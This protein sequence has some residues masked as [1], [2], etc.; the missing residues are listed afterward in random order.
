MAVVEGSCWWK[1]GEQQCTCTV[2]RLPHTHDG[3][4]DRA[5]TGAMEELASMPCGG[6]GAPDE[7]ASGAS[8]SGDDVT[9]DLGH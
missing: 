9:R 2:K 1:S 7:V 6:G 5:W 4:G 8:Y 3:A